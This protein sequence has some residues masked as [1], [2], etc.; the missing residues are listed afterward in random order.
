MFYFYLQQALSILFTKLDYLYN[1]IPSDYCSIEKKTI[2]LWCLILMSNGL[3]HAQTP[4]CFKFI[5]SD[6]ANDAYVKLDYTLK[7]Q[8]HLTNNGT[9]YVDGVY[10]R[11]L[12]DN[13]EIY[14]ETIVGVDDIDDEYENSYKHFIGPNQSELNYKLEVR[15]IGDGD[16]KC[17]STDIGSTSDFNIPTVFIA[18][19]PT[20]NLAIAAPDSTVITWTNNSRLATSLL[21]SRDDK[22]IKTFNLEND[23]EIIGKT[24][25]YVDKYSEED[26]NSLENGNSYTYSLQTVSSQTGQTYNDGIN[27]SKITDEGATVPINLIATYDTNSQLIKLSW[28]DMSNYCDDILIFR[29]S[30]QIATLANNA[31]CFPD[32]DPT[33]GIETPYSIQ[34]LRDGITEPVVISA[35]LEQAPKRG[36]IKGKVLAEAGDYPMEGAT[37]TLTG[38]VDNTTV[39]RTTLTDFAGCFFFDTI[40]YNRGST[41]YIEVEQE[42]IDFEDNADTLFL[43]NI[44]YVYDDL[45]FYGDVEYVNAENTVMLFDSSATAFPEKDSVALVWDYNYSA[46]DTTFFNI[47]RDGVLIDRINDAEEKITTYADLTGTPDQFHDYEV[48]FFRLMDNLLSR[49][50]IS[51]TTSFPLVT[52]PNSF[53]VEADNETGIV[54]LNWNHT[55]NNFAGFYLYRNGERIATL[56][57]HATSYIDRMGD[58]DMEALYALAAYRVVTQIGQAGQVNYESDTTAISGNAIAVVFPNLP[59][60]NNLNAI[61]THDYMNIS[62]NIPEGLV[63]DYNYTGFRIYRKIAGSLDRPA[64]IHTVYKHFAHADG[65]PSSTESF[66]YTDYRGIPNESYEYTV[67]TF[68]ADGVVDYERMASTSADYPNLIAPTNLSSS[69]VITAINLSWEMNADANNYD[70]FIILRD[71]PGD[72]VAVVRA[73]Q[74]T[75]R[76][77]PK[78]SD[79]GEK[80]DYQVKTYRRLGE[81]IYYSD[82]ITYRTS[83][84]Y[85]GADNNP[86]IP[87]NVTATKDQT[88]MI[89]V[90]W[91]YPDFIQAEFEIRRSPNSGEVLQATLS[92]TE[93]A[94]Y[95]YNVEPGINYNYD[96]VAK[97]VS[98]G[99]R[100]SWNTD[101]GRSRNFMRLSGR[102]YSYE[103]GMGTPN[104]KM[105][106]KDGNTIISTFFTDATGYYVIN[107]LDV[108]IGA[109]LTLRAEEGNV[110]FDAADGIMD[111]KE[112]T[113]AI[114]ANQKHYQQDFINY[115]EPP[116]PVTDTVATPVAFIAAGNY[117]NMS[118]ELSWSPGN[119]NYDGFNIY[120][121]FTENDIIGSVSRGAPFTF[122]DDAGAPGYSYVYAI[123]AYW[124][125]PTGRKVSEKIL[126]SIPYP[127]LFPVE[128]LVANELSGQNQVAIRWSHLLDNHTEYIVTRNDSLVATIPTGSKLEYID[129]TG[130]PGTGYYYKVFAV[131]KDGGQTYVSDE[132]I[133]EL[134]AYPDIKRVT[135]LSIEQSIETDNNV[136]INTASDSP[137]DDKV[138]SSTVRITW[139]YD[140]NAADIFEIYRDGQLLEQIN[141]DSLYYDDKTATPK[142]SSTS[143]TH[144]YEVIAGVVRN[145]QIYYSRGLSA[146]IT[147]D[148]LS[149]PYDFNITT[150][151]DKGWLELDWGYFSGEADGYH[152][153]RATHTNF[154]DADIL[155]T[156]TDG[157]QN[158]FIDKNDKPGVQIH[159][160]VQAF[161]KIN[162]I[163]YRS[164]LTFVCGSHHQVTFP[165]PPQ[166]TNVQASYEQFEGF[167]RITWEYDTDA[168]ID[169]FRIFKGF[170]G[171]SDPIIANNVDK[172]KRSYDYFTNDPNEISLTVL[173][174]RD[175]VRGQHSFVGDNDKGKIKESNFI[176]EHSIAQTRGTTIDADGEYIVV[177]KSK[178]G[179]ASL[180]INV[181]HYD[182]INWVASPSDLFFIDNPRTGEGLDISGKRVFVSIPNERAGETSCSDEVC[183]TQFGKLYGLDITDDNQLDFAFSHSTRVKNLGSAIAFSNGEFFAG[184]G[185]IPSTLECNPSIVE[186]DDVNTKTIGSQ[187]FNVENSDLKIK[188]PIREY[189]LGNNCDRGSEMEHSIVQNL[190][191]SI[192][193]TDTWVILG[194]SNHYPSRAGAVYIFKQGSFD[195]TSGKYETSIFLQAP[196][197]ETDGLFGFSVAI[198]GDRAIVGAPQTE[199]VSGGGAKGKAYIYRRVG[200]DWLLEQELVYPDG[201]VDADFGVAVD[202]KNDLAIVAAQEADKAFIYKKIDTEWQLKK[203]IS[204][205]DLP[206]RKNKSVVLTDHFAAMVENQEVKVINLLEPVFN[207]TAEDG[208][209]TTNTE[210]T[211]NY[212]EVGK[213]NGFYIYRDDEQIAS[214][215]RTTREYSDNEGVVGKPYT[216][217]VVAFNDIGESIGALDT[218]YR[219]S[220]GKISGK[221]VTLTGQA[222]VSGLTI[223][224]KGVAYASDAPNS[225]IDQVIEQT[226]TTNNA[227]EYIFE[228]IYYGA[229][230]GAY[231]VAIEGSDHTFSPS[232]QQLVELTPAI[233][234]R[235]NIDFFDEQAF[236][237]QGTLTH[238]DTDCVLEEVGVTVWTK[239]ANTDPIP[240]IKKTNDKGEYSIVI[241]PY[242]TQLEAIYVTVDTFAIFGDPESS[243]DKVYYTFDATVD[244]L[245]N[246]AAEFQSLANNGSTQIDFEQTLTYPVDVQLLNTC[247]TS[248][249]DQFTIRVRDEEGCFSREFDLSPEG[250]GTFHLPPLD[251][252]TVTAIKANQNTQIGLVALE[253]LKYRPATLHLK[254]AHFEYR[255]TLDKIAQELE[256]GD[257]TLAQA[258]TQKTEAEAILSQRTLA[259][260]TFHVTPNIFNTNFGEF[261][262][263]EIPIKLNQGLEY[264]IDFSITELHNGAN[265]HVEEGYL[266][267]NNPG[268]AGSD[269]QEKRIDYDAIIG[270]FDTYNFVAGTPNLIPPFRW[271]LEVK[272]FTANDEFLQRKVLPLLIEGSAAVP[273]YDVIVDPEDEV[274]NY[275]IYVL[276]DPPGDKSKVTIKAGKTFTQT[277][278]MEYDQNVGYSY[279]TSTKGKLFGTGTKL[280]YTVDAGVGFN[281]KFTFKFSGSLSEA[282]STSTGSL[283]IG[284]AG[285]IIVGTGIAYQYG[286]VEKLIVDGCGDP[287]K[288]INLGFTE[289][290]VKTEWVYTV[291]QMEAIAK[292]NEQRA[293]QIRAKSQKEQEE[294]ATELEKL[295]N[296]AANWRD[297][298]E[299]HR[300]RTVPHRSICQTDYAEVMRDADGN[301]YPNYH[302]RVAAAKVWQEN[303]CEE[304]DRDDII[305]DQDA[306][307]K[308]T[309]AINAIRHLA[310]PG[311]SLEELQVWLFDDDRWEG[312]DGYSDPIFDNQFG[313]AAENITF[314]GNTTVT[315]NMKST[316]SSSASF[317]IKANFGAKF[318]GKLETGQNVRTANGGFLGSY[319]GTPVGGTTIGYTTAQITEF[320]NVKTEFTKSLNIK[321]STKHNVTSTTNEF[322]D[323]TYVLS[324][325]DLGDQHSVTVVNGMGITHS[326]YF[327][328]FGG[329]SSCPPEDGTIFRDDPKIQIIDPGT[330]VALK[331]V[332]LE[333]QDPNAVA[334]VTIQV[335]NNSPFDEDRKV[336]VFLVN[337]SNPDGAQLKISGQILGTVDVGFLPPG[338]PQRF[339]MTIDRNLVYRYDGL[340]IG[341]RATCGGPNQ[342]KDYVDVNVN[343]E[344]P[345]T[346][347]TI[348]SPENGWI[349]NSADD[350]IVI[351][352]RDYQPDNEAFERLVLQYRRSDTDEEWDEV[353]LGELCL[354]LAQYADNITAYDDRY[355]APFDSERSPSA[356]FLKAFNE[357]FIGT[358]TFPFVWKIPED[359]L[360]FPD[361]EYQIRVMAMCD[362]SVN[363]SNTI[364]GQ[365]KRDVLRLIEAPKPANGLWLSNEDRVEAVFNQ[366]LDVS[367]ITNPELFEVEVLDLTTNTL[368][369]IELVANT[370]RLVIDLGANGVQNN[371][372]FL[373]D[374]DYDGHRFKVTINNATAAESQNQIEEPISW[375]FEVVTRRLYWAREKVTMELYEGQQASVNV[376]LK[377]TPPFADAVNNISLHAVNSGLGGWLDLTGQD[378]DN[379]N[380]FNYATDIEEKTITFLLNGNIETNGG[381][382][383]NTT[384]TETIEVVQN[385]DVL[386]TIDVELIIRPRPPHW[387][388]N[389]DD[390]SQRMRLTANWH[391]DDETITDIS[392]D[393]L[394]IISVYIDG[395]L[396]GYAQVEFAGNDYYAAYID[397]FGEIEDNGKPLEFRVWDS[398]EGIEYSGKMTEPLSY[399]AGALAG[400]T[401]TPRIVLVDRVL[402][403]A[404]YIPLRDGWTWFS[405]N[406]EEPDMSVNNLLRSLKN[407]SDCDII[408]TDDK[409]S[410]YEEGQGWLT[411]GI[412]ILDELNPAEGY[413]IYLENGPDTLRL[414]GRNTVINESEM[415]PGWNW[416]GYPPQE[417][418][419][420]GNILQFNPFLG[421]G[422]I[423]KVITEN[424]TSLIAEHNSNSWLPAN[425][426]LQLYDGIKL[427]VTN[428]DLV[429][430]G[431][432]LTPPAP[433]GDAPDNSPVNPNDASTWREPS[434][435]F[436]YVMPMVAEVLVNGDIVTDINDKLAFFVNGEIRAYVQLTEVS[437]FENRPEFIIP[438]GISDP[439]EEVEVRF[440][441][442]S[443]NRIFEYTETLAFT[444]KGYGKFSE[445]FPIELFIFKIEIEKRDVPCLADQSGYASLMVSEGFPPYTFKW[446]DGSTNSSLDALGVGVYKV[447]VS[448]ITN[449]P[450]VVEV[451][452]ENANL[453]ILPPNLS[454]NK[455]TVCEGS[456]VTLTAQPPLFE[457]YQT[458]IYWYDENN[459]LL[460]TGTELVLSNIQQS[461]NI[462][463]VTLVNNT[464]ASEPANI[465][466]TMF[467]AV[468]ATFSVDDRTPRVGTQEVTFTPVIQNPDVNYQWNF[469]DGTSSTEMIPQHTYTTED[470]F[471]VVLTTSTNNSCTNA[472]FRNKY[473]ITDN[474]RVI[475]ESDLDSDGDGL[476]DDCDNCPFDSNP[477]QD[478]DDNNGYGNACNCDAFEADGANLQI[479][480]NI[481][482]KSYTAT[483]TI[484]SDG[485]VTRGHV[486]FKAG[487][488]ITLH[489]G[490]TVDGTT[491][492]AHVTDVTDSGNCLSLDEEE[493]ELRS[494]EDDLELETVS[495]IL[496]VLPNPFQD[497]TKI[498]YELVE[499]SK[500]EV[501]IHYLTG[502]IIEIPVVSQ[503]QS[504]GRYELDFESNNLPAG[505]YYVR[506]HTGEQVQIQR[507][508]L[509]R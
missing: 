269:N 434:K 495:N 180:T 368:V 214:V 325:D 76:A 106:L 271:A 478:D 13:Q 360:R 420:I 229:F 411:D 149:Q 276:R 30:D 186:E 159:Y 330:G 205:L 438:V 152:I 25:K 14:A 280:S 469:G 362:G 291:A 54:N 177:N 10:I 211:W 259:Q 415:R 256:D 304:F 273:G 3:L 138:A 251:G 119:N 389:P 341:V 356:G 260:L 103:T 220:N 435:G 405:I 302:F 71:T 110:D 357:V 58:P 388:I 396:R 240:S 428:T 278:T 89:K 353:R 69:G 282:I 107:D 252:L 340:R 17:E 279:N 11:I 52:P 457:S 379:I 109:S 84:I 165:I 204:G 154:T 332:T 365:I 307:D 499:T 122:T 451:E 29:S 474:S 437:A 117:A 75:Y 93:R 12:L 19:D 473:I 40:F 431:Y 481:D 483:Q 59:A 443:R 194:S 426:D 68:I 188:R 170:G 414:T 497:H 209:S 463:A 130:T 476:K 200:N 147:P 471:S 104:V 23:D 303:Y 162:N 49:G 77:R 47:Y 237:I 322:I 472:F 359:K 178:R 155:T 423:L 493:S 182:G 158:A 221:V 445:P 406:S 216:Y 258:T 39:T 208:I 462:R 126:T 413:M 309:A 377:K 316:R 128:N 409:F 351:G 400:T 111:F 183:N 238:K 195:E 173:A 137:V 326:P 15:V 320:S 169:E 366:N 241:N 164:A 268:A 458:D 36:Q 448:D 32:D 7:K 385:S 98:D 422:S 492:L 230:R 175:G 424:N 371:H 324:D 215:G 452:I 480:G 498:I 465:E 416:I 197:Q 56:P 339:T 139:Q 441:D 288:E 328:R 193:A 286:L 333:D 143:T 253:Y 234:Q 393:L 367:G 272:Y 298:L 78:V 464:C 390:F 277:Y 198:D 319:A 450:V 342:R 382:P 343:F 284:E 97:R 334:E 83:T 449:F 263:E 145:G 329:R 344:T 456:S 96:V 225:A 61:A 266:I 171:S 92:P 66:T 468:D 358:P 502:E 34:L 361:G 176:A 455:T 232:A 364:T 376:L 22:V 313:K 246:N 442:A 231:T 168:L 73:G 391:F 323:M 346:P 124:D 74:L 500:T 18:S 311:R 297:I 444:E 95:D 504:A 505:M 67:S 79:Y 354:D 436:E 407:V 485:A 213:I 140:L 314:G 5:A 82:P 446:E 345:C 429:S 401:E 224:L 290:E 236:V 190:G 292:E 114:T 144:T 244:T 439:A 295:E 202:I 508:V 317:T 112:A 87:Y 247:G 374:G 299:Y 503:V 181:I 274:A 370:N 453:D 44:E 467:S 494:M 206:H 191:N 218:G 312:A 267:I 301:P 270:G 486:E 153:Y 399:K 179:G 285:D 249:G 45:L 507:M 265:C 250:L 275:P 65:I 430:V 235:G 100:S 70:G 308:Y 287:R 255:N 296:S 210:I 6:A 336:T 134:L 174:Y 262:C 506:L 243:N 115:F 222:P 300:K 105:V 454:A 50:A 419:T 363:L 387:Q 185:L 212:S 48:V 9:P 187:Q 53:M 203:T 120:R 199:E 421:E 372:Q 160:A 369:P 425:R 21:L 20:N 283:A 148:F 408:K 338:V 487:Q 63:A 433:T 491:F 62:W 380:N 373:V 347:V 305:W 131:F 146:D 375:E 88:G 94:F 28:D 335:T 245:F 226:T 8:E 392:K 55:S 166:V 184:Q 41:F 466:L 121:G 217:R 460:H 264:N 223:T 161:R 99:N 219:L 102:V 116:I 163:E 4:Q 31:I 398:V 150:N 201:E 60:P 46:E 16:K 432:G 1:K 306:I 227:G 129:N 459:N 90:C 475:C 127:I 394:D 479:A 410:I 488:S 132:R 403:R 355:Q 447:T 257:I 33:F 482:P 189:Q 81:I 136:C 254:T 477:N 501:S 427:N 327:Y 404:R 384:L 85:S 293:A 80:I 38:D 440:F 418:S 24:F 2:L 26:E 196:E 37:V 156:I 151:R 281:E 490:F 207:I 133:V 172:S 228:N 167:I 108:A 242:Q 496:T 135:D 386:T 412:R 113:I 348:V 57:I 397:V 239:I 86:D 192:D 378:G 233:Q 321:V 349:I 509:L 42:D 248:I 123:E 142:T 350:E 72:S 141:A 101:T 27:L 417:S 461:R 157:N 91:E 310:Y 64:L 331:E 402:D 489:S 484:T 43:S 35:D 289:S 125:T 352:V 294:L 318:Q 470:Q 383:F 315:R 261:V 118:V 395:E 51:L 337:S 381:T